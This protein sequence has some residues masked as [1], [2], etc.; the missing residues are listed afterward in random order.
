MTTATISNLAAGTY[1]VDIAD[2]AG[3]S[4]TASVTIINPNPTALA[5]SEDVSCF[6]NADGTATVSVENGSGNYTY[7]WSNNATTA[8]ISGLG[9]GT[10]SVVVTDQT[11]GCTTTASA[12]V[13]DP[14]ITADFSASAT[15]VDLMNSGMVQFTNNTAGATTWDWDFGDNSSSTSA[16]PSHTY[17][18]VGTYTVTV[19]VSNGTCADTYEFTITVTDTTSSVFSINGVDKLQVSPNPTNGQFTLNINTLQ[20]V[21]LRVKVINALGQVVITD[22]LGNVNGAFSKAYNLDQF[23]KGLYFLQVTDGTSA[24]TLKVV[25]F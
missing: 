16:S 7:A 21:D 11:S 22:E 23:A 9:A 12:T 2:G 20:G 24:S 25:H 6:D 1:T 3:C 18:A 5:S 19:V 8:S 4:T 14:S 15:A 13:A 17:N 10:Y